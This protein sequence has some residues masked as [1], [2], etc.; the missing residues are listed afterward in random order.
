M[1]RGGGGVCVGVWVRVFGVCGGSF[2]ARDGRM[3][4]ESA[5]R[6]QRNQRGRTDSNT[7]IEPNEAVQREKWI[8]TQNRRIKKKYFIN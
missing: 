8:E 2:K 6:D 4:A 1:R 5:I 3:G 7:P